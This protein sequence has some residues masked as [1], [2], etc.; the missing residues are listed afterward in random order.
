MATPEEM[1]QKMIE[2]L[3][4]KTG[5]SLEEW[6]EILSSESFQKHGETVK[7]LK[8]SF[9]I[10]HGFANLIAKFHLSADEKPSDLSP[11][12]LLFKG[13]E[14]LLPVFNALKAA[15]DEITAQTEFAYK[16]SYIS[17]RTKKQY[18][19]VQPSTQ[20]RLDLGL[21][22]KGKPAEGSLEL[23]GSF[24]SMVSHRVKLTEA[25]QVDDALKAWITEAYEAS[26]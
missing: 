26:L 17:L 18:A 13:K 6:L 4:E 22:L 19:I 20:T 9:G 3:P 14:G 23:S 12:E 8:A 1:A 24:N 7:W 2:N 15:I 25:S 21:N 5:K 16:K 10:T 11:D